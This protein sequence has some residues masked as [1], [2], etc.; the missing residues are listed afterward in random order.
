MALNKDF[1]PQPLAPLLNTAKAQHSDRMAKGMF[2]IPAAQCASQLA[3]TDTFSKEMNMIVKR[4]IGKYFVAT[5]VASATLFVSEVQAVTI[6]FDEFRPPS[7]VQQLAADHYANLGVLF[8]TITADGLRSG[9]TVVREP[10]YGIGATSDPNAVGFGFQGRKLEA[11]FVDPIAGGLAVSD[12]VSL[13]VGDLSSEADP[14]SVQAFDI[15][16]LLL[17]TRSFT[18]QPTNTLGF[19]DFGSLSFA[20]SG[21]HRLVISDRSLSGAS[22]DDF[23]FSRVRVPTG[24]TAV[25]E[26]GTCALLAAGIMGTL[27]RR[28]SRGSDPSAVP[29]V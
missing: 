12:F 18:S 21:I 13:T 24:G 5:A 19:Q 9:F 8:T 16:G 29:C 15:G 4:W 28:K 23:N 26:P 2:P 14:I 25:P 20:I 7:G 22:L 1:Q 10:I 27:A 6:N 17:G 3:G 11:T